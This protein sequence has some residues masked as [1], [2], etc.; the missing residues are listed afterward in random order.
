MSVVARCRA[1]SHRLLCERPI[2][3]LLVL[4]LSAVAVIIWHTHR[5]QY[6][7]VEAQAM[8]SA[9]QLADA[10]AKFRTIYTSEVVERVRQQGITITHDYQH[11]DGAIPLPATLSMMLGNQIGAGDSNTRTRLYSAFPFPWRS[12]DGGLTDEFAADAWE[13][14]TQNPDTAFY[15]LDEVDGV[16]VLRY[17]TADVMRSACV[18]CHNSHPDSPKTDWKIGDVRGV[19]EVIEPLVDPLAQSHTGL[20]DTTVLMLLMT[21]GGLLVI[22]VILGNLRRVAAEAQD[23]A[24]Q[25]NEANSGLK[26]EVTERKRAEEELLASKHDL[27]M[28]VVDLE[29][30]QS[31]LEM[32]GQ[33]LV[34]LADDLFIARDKV[35]EADRA[36]SEF[37]ATMSHELRTPLNAI[38]GFSEIIANE[39]LG[40]VGNAK[41]RQ[42]AMDIQASGQHL[43][44]LINDI[45]DL[46]KIES[47]KDELRDDEIE[48]P[49]LVHSALNLVSQGAERD[50]IRL[51]LDLPEQLPTLRADERK[52]KQ[53]LVNLLSNAVKFTATGGEVKLSAWCRMDSG[54]VFQVVD[55]GIGIAPEDIP[56][57]FSRFGQVDGK[58]SRQYQGTGLGLPLTKAL[59]ELHSG[60]IDLQSDLGVG[61]TVT[62]SFPAERAV[63][64]GQ[65]VGAAT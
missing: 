49:L 56:K 42:Y 39:I 8:E 12:A 10:L 61:T 53:I 45:L 28:R 22:G 54:Y 37:V 23:L 19:L 15:R 20:V 43:L 29:E 11:K 51:S 31:M 44:D 40:P 48:I 57:V 26:K 64:A 5:Q 63:Q 41:Y 34:G 55:T 59:I 35:A 1:A 4:F 47:G 58:L 21:L 38:I 32:Q 36:K 18:D 2:A 27:Q 13:A 60:V 52:L 16:P 46:S 7:L 33:S 65:S 17:A 62:V 3:V 30:A 9:K 50:G 14:L 6:A 24:E 25:T